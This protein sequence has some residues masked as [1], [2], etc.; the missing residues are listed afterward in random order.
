[1]HQRKRFISFLLVV[2]ILLSTLYLPIGAT[3]TPEST[4]ANMENTSVLG[5][6]AAIVESS[7]GVPVDFENEAILQHVDQEVFRASN[8]IRRLPEEETL[9]TYVY[10]NQDGTKSVYFMDENVKYVDSDGKVQNKDISLKETKNGFTTVQNDVSVVIPTNAANG[11]QVSHTIGNLKLIPEN[12]L[13][14]VA[15]KQDGNSV[16]YANY[17]GKGI[18]LRYTPLLSGVK[19]DI[20]LASY[21]GKHSFQF[22]LDTNG[23]FVYEDAEEGYYVAATQD[24][25]DRYYLGEILVYDAVGRPSM[26]TM[27]VRTVTAGAR[28]ILAV[29]ADPA[30][31]TDTDTV[32]PVTIDPTITVGGAN[33][34]NKQIWDV[35]IF[36]GYPTWTCG[37]YQYLT[38]GNAG[39][40]YGTGRAIIKLP[41]LYESSVFQSTPAENIV[42]VKFYCSDGSGNASQ[43]VSLHAHMGS[44]TWT[45]SNASW[46]SVGSA[47]ETSY[48]WGTYVSHGTWTEFNITELAQI[49]KTNIYIPAAGF[50][51]INA[52]EATRD[53]HKAIHATEYTTASYRP[54]VVMTYV[55]NLAISNTSLSIAE[56]GI[57]TLTATTN[58]T[59]L[60]LSWSSSNTAVATVSS[61]G[62][63][64]G[65][66]AGTAVITVTALDSAGDSYTAS[67]TVYIY[68]QDGVYYIQNVGSGL[69]L[70]TDSGH[71]YAS[72]LVQQY[73]KYTDSADEITKLRQ[74]WRIHY[75][76]DGRYSIRPMHRMIMGLDV[77]T[78]STNIVIDEIG[79]TDTLSHVTSVSMTWTIEWQSNGYV[80]QKSGADRYTLGVQVTTNASGQPVVALNYD[81]TSVNQRWT[82]IK[83][84]NPP[85]GIILYDGDTQM[86]VTNTAKYYITKEQEKTIYDFNFVIAI[87]SADVLPQTLNWQAG[88]SNVLEINSANG[89]VIGKTAGTSTVSAGRTINGVFCSQIFSIVVTPLPTG[90]YTLNNKQTDCFADIQSQ[91][92]TNGTTIHQWQFHGG[93]TQKWHFDLLEDG[94]Y[95]IRSNNS[96]T[97]YYLGVIND[98]SELNID[99]VLRSGSIT[100]GMKWKIEETTSGAFKLIPKT[101]ETSD[102]VLATSTSDATNG[103]KLIQG[104]YVY[105]DSYRDE[106]ILIKTNDVSLVALPEDYDR[107]SFFA[108]IEQDLETIGYSDNY[109]NHLT[110][111][112]GVNQG[113]LLSRMANSKILLV[114]TH[115]S[116][117]TITT[118]DGSLTR[119]ELL[120]L[121]TDVF[122]ETEMIIYG[123]CLTGSGKSGADNLVNATYD[124]GAMVV[125]GFEKRVWNIE[126]NIWCEEFFKYI[127]EGHTV[128]SACESAVVTT[129][130]KWKARYNTDEYPITTDSYYI[131]GNETAVFS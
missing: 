64:T 70:H 3:E 103:A 42:S 108:D 113:E 2:S 53:K 82:L 85:S 30:F 131:A 73:T 84:S 86:P 14:V 37:A 105:N 71:I 28:Y 55:V 100:N 95:A 74:L 75:L 101:G 126:V 111:T 52:D 110:V 98:S 20:I 129:T 46:N 72:T 15:G 39:G 8:H 80:F 59:G 63:V 90:M 83:M 79:T 50:Q 121:S 41:G 56:G 48:D 88:N 10:L 112:N 78:A 12:S 96:S 31:L 22:A 24:A 104:A 97:S 47:Y 36:S 114:R 35:P 123:A 34:T 122:L 21:T 124:R 125:I 19:E 5:T 43:Y 115:G 7:I 128:K 45:E 6:N 109:N 11:I 27:A 17:F 67:C 57:G 62:V 69:Y 118:S 58:P 89:T 4:V 107:S 61:A 1:M 99:V 23:L 49:W 26:G 92:M 77:K 127:S 40:S 9:D 13:M 117:T 130:Q 44:T 116:K 51:L 120:A 54:Y 87:Y 93:N 32:Y 119:S 16:L 60:P 102:Y 65:V 29:A 91:S 81:A 25:E 18:S 76:G 68:I 94:Y 38:L 66:K 106:W 33:D